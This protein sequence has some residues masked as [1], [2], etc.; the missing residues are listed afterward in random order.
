MARSPI[1]L[2]ST[3]GYVVA[4]WKS[5]VRAGIVCSIQAI[6]HGCCNT[7]NQCHRISTEGFGMDL[8]MCSVDNGLADA[9]C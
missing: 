1:N 3:P 4:P 9:N 7:M 5:P 6:L 8:V 2:K